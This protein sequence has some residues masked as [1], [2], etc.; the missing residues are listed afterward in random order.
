MPPFLEPPPGEQ[1][2]QLAATLFLCYKRGWLK[3][4]KIGLGHSISVQEG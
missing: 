1:V 2:L 4:K 3:E